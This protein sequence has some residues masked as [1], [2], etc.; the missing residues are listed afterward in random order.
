MFDAA[1]AIDHRHIKAIGLALDPPAPA[2]CGRSDGGPAIAVQKAM[3]APNLRTAR[4][5]NRRSVVTMHDAVL[6][7]ELRAVR[8]NDRRC[9][10]AMG[11]ALVKPKLRAV[12]SHNKGWLLRPHISNCGHRDNRE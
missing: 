3:T 10:V 8:G 11:Q 4:P 6:Q 9:A 5:S 12:R 1:A 7:P 2:A